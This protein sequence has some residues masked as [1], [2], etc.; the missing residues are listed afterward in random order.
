MNL[1]SY[2]EIVHNDFMKAAFIKMGFDESQLIALQ[3]FDYKTT[4]EV[5]EK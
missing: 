1:N 2:Y 5:I 3:I 4:V